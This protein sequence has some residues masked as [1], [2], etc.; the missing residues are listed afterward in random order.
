MQHM[1]FTPPRR[2]ASRFCGLVSRKWI[3]TLV[4]VEENRYPVTVIL[5]HALQIRGLLELLT[6]ERLDLEADDP[7][8]RSCSP[9]RQRARR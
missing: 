1:Q 3:A 2:S 7:A 5:E 4:S 6:D 9:S 8:E